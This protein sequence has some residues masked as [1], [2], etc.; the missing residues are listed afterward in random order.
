MKLVLLEQDEM[1]A[2]ADRPHNPP[3]VCNQQQE[4]SFQAE[5]RE[6]YKALMDSLSLLGEEGDYYGVSDFA[7]RPDLKD[8]RTVKAPPASHVRELTLTILS[9]TFYR[10]PYLDVLH[11]VLR[12]S[13]PIYRLVVDQ[14][15]D[16]QWYLA[17]FLTKD[18]ASVYC[19]SK[20][21]LERLTA[22]LSGL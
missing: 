3:D 9:E 12:R 14:D 5:V 11:N 21:E 7:I 22:A 8:R 15:F 20:E 18:V 2:L 13:A 10:C 1:W 6:V 16:P 19:T 4:N 17:L